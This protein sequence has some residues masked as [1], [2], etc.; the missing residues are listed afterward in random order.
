[1]LFF[2]ATA[3]SFIHEV[4][5]FFF[6]ETFGLFEKIPTANLDMDLVNGDVMFDCL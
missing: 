6:C 2:S 5:L 1:M 4:Y 3:S